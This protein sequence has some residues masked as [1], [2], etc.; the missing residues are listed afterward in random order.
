MEP[1]YSHY[2]IEELIITQIEKGR[3]II[4]PKFPK[5]RKDIS[6]KIFCTYS[7]NTTEEITGR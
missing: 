6:A 7:M 1:K 5:T 2:F 3:V 4:L